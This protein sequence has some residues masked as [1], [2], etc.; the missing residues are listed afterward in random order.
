[1]DE[2][3]I[4]KNQL[5]Y[6]DV[7]FF[8]TVF[9]I[10]ALMLPYAMKLCG[11]SNG[12]IL[13]LISALANVGIQILNSKTK[14]EKNIELGKIITHMVGKL[15]TM[16]YLIYQL[17]FYQIN[18][19]YE[20]D[21]NSWIIPF[22]WSLVFSVIVLYLTVFQKV[23][24]SVIPHLLTILTAAIIVIYLVL[25]MNSL[26]PKVPSFND[27][28]VFSTGISEKSGYPFMI[29][30]MIF[31]SH[32]RFTD[33]KQRIKIT[34]TIC[35]LSAWYFVIGLFGYLSLL[36]YT[37]EIILFGAHFGNYK[38]LAF[39][40]M[41]LLF[42]CQF[43]KLLVYLNF[44]KKR[45]PKIK[46][47]QEIL[48]SLIFIITLVISQL[49]SLKSLVYISYFCFIISN[50]VINSITTKRRFGFIFIS[51]LLIGIATSSLE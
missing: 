11:L 7:R 16:Q 33:I 29:C 49:L 32:Y 46:K 19:Y 10:E 37:P 34:D 4:E 28:F 48:I 13:I 20:F 51:I 3:L 21:L 38:I 42:I 45:L 22:I 24:D 12:F 5:G 14:Q 15:I 1:M 50:L 27:S 17:W 43:W 47:S 25:D 40:S 31:T 2:F 36:D 41:S 30:I 35:L 44:V 39:L 26:L 23:K 6:L 18:Y 8:G 9:G